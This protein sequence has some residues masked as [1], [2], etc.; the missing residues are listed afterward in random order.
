MEFYC[1]SAS[2]TFVV[3]GLQINLLGAMMACFNN[4][5][6]IKK[7][8]TFPLILRRNQSLHYKGDEVQETEN[9]EWN[10]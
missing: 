8:R 1:Y 7:T 3:L 6:R 2:E 10:S 5:G 4:G 9:K